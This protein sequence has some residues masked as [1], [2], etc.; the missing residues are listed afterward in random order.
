MTVGEFYELMSASYDATGRSFFG[1]HGRDIY[2]IYIC[3]PYTRILLPGAHAVAADR[4]NDIY[5][6]IL[7]L[8]YTCD[9]YTRIL[10]CRVLTLWPQTETYLRG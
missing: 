5:I 7:Y 8:V 10:Y 9:P 3:D 4:D 2:Y 1:K 6:Y